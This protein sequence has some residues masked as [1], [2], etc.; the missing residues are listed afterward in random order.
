[1]NSIEEIVKALTLEENSLELGAG[2]LAQQ[3]G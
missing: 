3:V 1:M 2:H